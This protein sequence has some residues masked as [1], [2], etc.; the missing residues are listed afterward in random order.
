ML[1]VLVFECIDL[2]NEYL[3]NADNGQGRGIQQWTKWKKSLTSDAQIPLD[4]DNMQINILMCG[5][6]GLKCYR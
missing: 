2:F 3:Q 5:S 4:K 1:I 6:H